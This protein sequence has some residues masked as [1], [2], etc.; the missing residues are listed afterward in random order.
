MQQGTDHRLERADQSGK[1]ANGM[2]WN[3]KPIFRKAEPLRADNNRSYARQGIDQIPTVHLGVAAFQMEKRGIRTERGNINREIEV[4][5]S[6]IRQLKARIN[7]LKNWLKE[8][9]ENAAPPTL[10]DVFESMLNKK[11]QQGRYK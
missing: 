3:R 11:Q 6:Q 7:K 1:M 9:A 5:N 4:T 8:E 2:G 10:A